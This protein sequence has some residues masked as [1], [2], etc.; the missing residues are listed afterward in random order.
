MGCSARNFSSCEKGGLDRYLD[1]GEWWA[2]SGGVTPDEGI[3]VLQLSAR[4]TST[5]ADS[6]SH[7]LEFEGYR[8]LGILPVGMSLRYGGVRFR[9]VSKVASV[10]AYVAMGPYLAVTGVGWDLNS[11]L[12][13]LRISPIVITGIAHR[14]HRDRPS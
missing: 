3:F 10:G 13:V 12:S 6:V 7:Y 1:K 14:D 4:Q 8:A 11:R 5:P 2:I 9:H